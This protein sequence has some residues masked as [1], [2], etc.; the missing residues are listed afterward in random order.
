MSESDLCDRLT[1]DK[2]AQAFDIAAQVTERAQR[3]FSNRFDIF[4]L[5]LDF[6]NLQ[7]RT[8]RIHLS[9]FA[10]VLSL[11]CMYK[12]ADSTATTDSVRS[13]RM[14]EQF[15][16]ELH[17]FG[18]SVCVCSF[19]LKKFCGFEFKQMCVRKSAGLNF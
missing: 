17:D 8:C 12:Y 14:L 19:V 5:A 4:H 10:Q 18:E 2:A 11:L 1:L 15:W 16:E 3:K 13:Q 9:E 6:R 7:K